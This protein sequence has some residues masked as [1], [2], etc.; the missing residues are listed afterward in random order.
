[1]ISSG[2]IPCRYLEV[3]PRLACP[4]CL[5]MMFSGTPSRASSSACAWRSLWGAKRRLTPARAATR[6]NSARTAA[7]DHGRPRVGPSMMQNSGPTGSS[8][9]APSHG[10]HVFPAPLVH[11]DLAPPAALAA[12]NQQRTARRVEVVFGERERLLDAQPGAPEHD[13][14]RAQPSPVTVWRMTATVSST[15]GGRRGSGCPCCATGGR[16]GSRAWS[17]ASGAAQAASS[18]VKTVTGPRRNGQQVTRAA[19]SGRGRPGYRSSQ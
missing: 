7:P 18:T 16:R 5:W 11:A 8:A 6:R 17:P 1:M 10:A 14:H 15:V 3:V 9:R 4:S 13:D 12:A 2:S 19:V